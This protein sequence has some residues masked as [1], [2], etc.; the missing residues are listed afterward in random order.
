VPGNLNEGHGSLV[1]QAPVQ[2][3][4]AD[5]ESA[6]K[7]LARLLGRQIARQQIAAAANAK[8]EATGVSASEGRTDER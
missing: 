6:L 4:R 5:G 1:G 7:A 2:S 3:G 8:S